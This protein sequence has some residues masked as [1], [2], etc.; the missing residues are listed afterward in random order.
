MTL[1]DKETK[2]FDRLT[3][4]KQQRESYGLR[5]EHD[6][7]IKL[8]RLEA[9]KAVVPDYQ[10]NGFANRASRRRSAKAA[11]Y[12]THGWSRYRAPNNPQSIK[13]EKS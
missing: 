4:L 2:E 5:L 6:D 7:R 8:D 9:K 12:L 13:K 3:R 11:G 1:T 10:F